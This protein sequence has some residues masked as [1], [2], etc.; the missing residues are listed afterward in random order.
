MLPKWAWF[1]RRMG[2]VLGHFSEERD[3]TVALWRALPYDMKVWSYHKGKP[4]QPSWAKMAMQIYNNFGNIPV[5]N[6]FQGML[7]MVKMNFQDEIGGRLSSIRVNNGAMPVDYAQQLID[8]SQR[9]NGEEQSGVDISAG[10]MD[11]LG[12]ELFNPKS[13]PK[14]PF[15][16]TSPYR[17]KRWKKGVK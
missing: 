1:L 6:L 15:V 16:R 4:V 13:P 2:N 9:S 7:N 12:L 14:A 17:R 3:M 5:E 11:F 10:I 8:R